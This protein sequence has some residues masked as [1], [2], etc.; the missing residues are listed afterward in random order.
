MS[1]QY[2]I[3]E[4]IEVH[5][6][7]IA[8]ALAGINLTLAKLVE[9]TEKAEQATR[10]LEIKKVKVKND[11]FA[12]FVEGVTARKGVSPEV[13][14]ENV[15]FGDAYIEYEESCEFLK[16]D[17]ISKNAFARLIHGLGY[18]TKTRYENNDRIFYFTSKTQ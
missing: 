7:A 18:V 13:A 5:Y 6:G 14:F 3:L 15:D 8:T 2:E 11:S 12:Q 9:A 4:R 10:D 16:V 1:K 17:R